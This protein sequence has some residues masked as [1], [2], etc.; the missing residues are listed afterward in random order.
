VGG[1]GIRPGR[2]QGRSVSA[3]SGRARRGARTT[4][5]VRRSGEALARSERGECKQRRES[6]RSER[7]RARD[8][9]EKGIARLSY[10]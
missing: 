1:G 2:E 5:S 10:L 6:A 8:R 9:G 3:D 4:G 7:E